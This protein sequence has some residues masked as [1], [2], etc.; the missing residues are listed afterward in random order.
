M[1]ATTDPT[2]VR[3]KST[4]DACEAFKSLSHP[5]RIGFLTEASRK[6]LSPNTYAVAHDEALG[7]VAYH[8]RILLA[9]GLIVEAH[10]RSRRG[11][12]EHFYSLTDDG[13]RAVYLLAAVGI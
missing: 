13:W 2:T 1:T 10:T 3:F 5:V 11:A 9:S 12:L 8:A 4:A 6:P 7:T